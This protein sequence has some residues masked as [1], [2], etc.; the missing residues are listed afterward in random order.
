MS[1][2][3][4]VGHII[5]SQ[6]VGIFSRTMPATRLIEILKTRADPPEKRR[7]VLDLGNQDAYGVPTRWPPSMVAIFN[8]DFT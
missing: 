1:W 2:W 6:V 8:I 7:N 5:D 3:E 4:G